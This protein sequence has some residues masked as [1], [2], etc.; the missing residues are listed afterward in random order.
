[1]PV[2]LGKNIKHNRIL[3]SRTVLLHFRAED[4]PGVPSLEKVQTEKLGGGFHRIVA[5]Y[6]F[7]EDPQLE[8]VLFLAREQGLDL[9]PE[10]TSFYL[11]RESLVYTEA[12][13]M[14]RWRTALFVFLSRNAADA[15][16]FFNLPADRVIQVGVRLAI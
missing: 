8:S 4:V 9:N 6:G 12:P 13:S 14:A 10:T 15:T 11:G 16:S 1:V 5:R 2:A 7:M 3:H